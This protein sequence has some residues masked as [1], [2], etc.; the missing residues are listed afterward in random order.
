MAATV[1]GLTVAPA[2]ASASDGSC[3]GPKPTVSTFLH[4]ADW[5]EN[6]EFDGHGRIWIANL[7]A[8][9]LEAYGPAGDLRA[10]VPVNAPGA[11]RRGPDG[12]LYANFGNNATS[13][14]APSGVV[15]FDP[16]HPRPTVY[17]TGDAFGSANGAEFDSAGNLYVADPFAGLVKIRP[18]GRVDP[19]W[20]TDLPGADGVATLGGQVFTTLLFDPKSAVVRVTRADATHPKTLVELSPDGVG[21][22]PDDMAFGP[23]LRLYVATYGSGEVFRTDLAGRKCV[24]LSG[25]DHPTSVRFAQWFGRPGDMYVTEASGSVLRVRLGR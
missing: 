20:K 12:L 3:P 6:A 1:L 17:A 11:I 22:L 24:L 19:D 16:E 14:G 2:T 10:T 21:K 23:D 18:G 15:R 7:T 4:S 13:H 9:R 5:Y 8:N 25:L